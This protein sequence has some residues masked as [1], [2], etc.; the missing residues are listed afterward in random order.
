MGGIVRRDRANV[1]HVLPELFDNARGLSC[2]HCCEPIESCVPIPRIYDTY[3]C[4]YHVFGATCS[5]NCAKAYIIE[6]TSF[7][8]GRHINVLTHML[9]A[10]YGI[11]TPIIETPPRAAL[12]RFGGMFDPQTRRTECKIVQPPFVSYSM[13]VEEQN[14]AN[15]EE[16]TTPTEEED[17]LGEPN[18]PALFEAFS[19]QRQASRGAR[20]AGRKRPI[21]PSR[22]APKTT[23]NGPLARF[24]KKDKTESGAAGIN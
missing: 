17:V 22:T 8:R 7:D 2:W 13:I 5:P 19:A 11:T 18:P 24:A 15:V 20:E 9:D 12:R 6:H 1:Y 23:P 14:T 4:V 16:K 10:V 21:E 3:E